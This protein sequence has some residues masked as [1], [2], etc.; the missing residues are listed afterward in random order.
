MSS[1]V[2]RAMPVSTY[3]RCLLA[4]ASTAARTSASRRALRDAEVEREWLAAER[5]TKGNMLNRRGREAGID[6]K[7]LFRGPESR[8][9]KY[10]SEELLNY[11]GKPP[12]ADRSLVPRRGHQTRHDRHSA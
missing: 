6:E 10:A 5:E 3:T 9:R 4:P 12:A 1:M 11:L 7:S 2:V 8:A